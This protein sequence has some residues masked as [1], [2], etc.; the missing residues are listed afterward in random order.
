MSRSHARAKQK[1]AQVSPT[2]TIQ[3][4]GRNLHR[5]LTDGTRAN[6]L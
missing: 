1:S 2:T 6:D 4:F 3:G 5:S